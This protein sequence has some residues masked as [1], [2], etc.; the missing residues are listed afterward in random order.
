MAYSDFKNLGQA[1]KD[2]SLN[3]ENRSGLFSNIQPI[4][5]SEK[6]KSLLADY[7]ELATNIGTEKARSELIVAPIL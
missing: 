1:V 2:L 5:P 3:L 4:E 6:L 7:L